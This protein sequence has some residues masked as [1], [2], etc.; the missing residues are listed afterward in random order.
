MAETSYT[1]EFYENFR[2]GS[3]RSAQVVVPIVL[4]FIQAK[5]VVDVGCG[6]GAWLLEFRKN[7]VSEIVGLDGD[8]VDRQLLQ[9]PQDQFTVV[10]LSAPFNLPRTFDLAV[11]LEVAEHLPAS[12]A[13]GFVHSLTRLAPVVLFSAAIPFQDGTHHV[14]EQWPNYWVRLFES[15]DYLPIDCIR[16]RTWTNADV[17]SW[18]AQNTLLF[19]S[20]ARIQSD[21]VLRREYEATDIRNLARVHPR[22]YLE[23]A[24]PGV[25]AASRQLI[26][27]ARRRIQLALHKNDRSK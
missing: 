25:R 4:E 18:Y 10:D 14:N 27:A 5:T 23:V 19:A 9:I 24:Q 16:P 7:G 15:H 6:I 3:I 20:A 12:A 8:Y 13:E 22:A 26:K 11:S 17:E 1:S 2:S 21:P